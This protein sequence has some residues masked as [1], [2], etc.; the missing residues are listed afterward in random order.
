MAGKRKFLAV[1]TAH[2]WGG[3]DQV[4]VLVVWWNLSGVKSYSSMSSVGTD[5]KYNRLENRLQEINKNWLQ[6][7]A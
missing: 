4:V 2:N 3:P 5:T 7:L 6:G 1:V